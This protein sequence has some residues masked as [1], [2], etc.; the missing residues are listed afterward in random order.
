MPP[1]S[2]AIT[3]GVPRNGITCQSKLPADSI[4]RAAKFCVEPILT[5][6]TFSLPGLARA[7][8]IS[9]CAVPNLPPSAATSAISNV[10][11]IDTGAKSFAASNGKLL[12][13]P[14]LTAVPLLISS[15]VCP[16]ASAFATKSPATIPPALGLLSIT[17]A[18]PKLSD[19]FCATARAVKS[20]TPPAPN[21]TMILSGLLGKLCAKVL[22]AARADKV[23]R[24]CLRFIK[25]S[26]KG[27]DFAASDGLRR[28]ILVL[29]NA[30]MRRYD[31]YSALRLTQSTLAFF[32]HKTTNS[33]FRYFWMLLL[34]KRCRIAALRLNL[35]KG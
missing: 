25:V 31:L 29:Q 34:P 17:T 19:S 35:V 6:P 32:L 23:N 12:N 22:L 1:R 10:P 3:S 13:N 26:I 15:S 2:A 9:S 28:V 4:S 30:M 8:A 16:S 5:V 20:A 33:G 27:S 18:C 21:G 14:V 24:N 11:K 7:N